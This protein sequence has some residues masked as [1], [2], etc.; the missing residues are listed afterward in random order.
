LGGFATSV[1]LQTWSLSTPHG[2]FVASAPLRKRSAFVAGNDGEIFSSALLKH[3]DVFQQRDHPEDDDDDAADL[4]GAAVE[5]QQ[6]DEIE[7]EDYD[8]KRDE[9]AGKHAGAPSARK[10]QLAIC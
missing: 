2:I 9:Y 1:W 3:R 7:N 10:A 8:E 5:R 6:V 4:L